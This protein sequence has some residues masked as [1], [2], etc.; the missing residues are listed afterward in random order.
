M[1]FVV[2]TCAVLALASGCGKDPKTLLAPGK[3]DLPPPIGGLTFGMA[4]ADA[5]AAAAPAGRMIGDT[6]YAK[7]Y[8]KTQIELVFG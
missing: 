3:P 7:G 1:R 6:L 2:V 5:L 4:K 8:R